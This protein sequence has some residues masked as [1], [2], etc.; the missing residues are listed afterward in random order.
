MSDDPL[1]VFSAFDSFVSRPFES[2]SFPTLHAL[3][4]ATLAKD[5]RIFL[6]DIGISED[7]TEFINKLGRINPDGGRRPV[8]SHWSSYYNP[9][10]R[11]V[12]LDAERFVFGRWPE[13]NSD[14]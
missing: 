13:F 7:E 14:C 6:T 12:V 5:L 8:N 1:T 2:K 3:N 11:L 10:L 9:S 4:M